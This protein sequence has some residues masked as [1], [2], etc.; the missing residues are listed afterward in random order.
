MQGR[1]LR[2]RGDGS[3]LDAG[4]GLIGRSADLEVAEGMDT[5]PEGSM[6]G[7]GAEFRRMEIVGLV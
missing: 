1:C 5:R 6:Y 2:F 4:L 7:G 3:R